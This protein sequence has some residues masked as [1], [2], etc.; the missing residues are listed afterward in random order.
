VKQSQSPSIKT[1]DVRVEL[2]RDA[3]AKL[4]D[5]TVLNTVNSRKGCRHLAL[6]II[7]LLDEED[8]C[9]A[10]VSQAVRTSR[11]STQRLAEG[12]SGSEAITNATANDR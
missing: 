12:S 5:A 1:S 9:E 6:E 7:Q 11:T 4:L 8:G 2:I 10:R 3:A